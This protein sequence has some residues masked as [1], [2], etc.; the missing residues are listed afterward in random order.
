M[1]KL[2]SRLL[3]MAVLLAAAVSFSSHEAVA[4]QHDPL[5]EAPDGGGGSGGIVPIGSIDSGEPDVGQTGRDRPGEGGGPGSAELMQLSEL[6][7]ATGWFRWL[8]VMW[9]L[10]YLGLGS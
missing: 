5:L 7:A 6:R 8:A 4:Q 9:T 3:F 2:G 1:V 10:R